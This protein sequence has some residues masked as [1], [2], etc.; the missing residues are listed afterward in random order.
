MHNKASVL[1]LE[2]DGGESSKVN[3]VDGEAVAFL[4]SK[5]SEGDGKQFEIHKIGTKSFL[6]YFLPSCKSSYPL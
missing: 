3:G 6:F 2:E 4:E 1:A 5:T